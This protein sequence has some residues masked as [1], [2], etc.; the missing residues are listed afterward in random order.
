MTPIFNFLKNIAN[1]FLLLL[2]FSLVFIYI[3]FEEI[4]WDLIANPIYKFLESFHVTKKIDELLRASNRYIILVVFVLLFVAVE[5]LGI[6][7][8]GLLVSGNILAG[9]GLY[10]A[11]IPIAIFTFW[12]FKVVRFKLMTFDWFRLS[13][14][15]LENILKLIKSS[16]IY[17]QTIEILIKTKEYIRHKQQYLKAK[18]IGKKSRFIYR[19]KR[20]YFLIKQ[21]YK[22]N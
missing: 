17:Q 21:R 5:L 20:F 22:G 13:F 3:I 8:G 7:A 18:F 16:H 9:I 4:I 14:D 11:K 19:I 12:M 2:Q 1:K 15:I 6:V 10:L